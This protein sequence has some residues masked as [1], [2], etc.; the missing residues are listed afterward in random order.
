MKEN[1]IKTEKK[2]VNFKTLKRLVLLG[3]PYKITLFMVAFLAVFLSIVSVASTYLMKVI[4]DDYILKRDFYGMS[5]MVAIKFSLLVIEAAGMISFSYYTRFLAQNVVRD[6]RNQIFSYMIRF[7]ISYYNKSSVGVLVTRV[8]SDLERVSDVFSSGFFEIIADILKIIAILAVMFYTNWKLALVVITTIPIIVYGTFWFQKLMR[9]AFK[10]V[11]DQVTTLNSFVQERISGMKIVQLF[12]QED[13]TYQKFEEINRKH[14]KAWLKNIWLN[15]VFFPFI[16][17]VSSLAIALIVW[18]GGLQ[19]L[20]G[21]MPF[22][23]ILMFIQLTRMLF[24]PLRQIADKYN[25]LQLGMVS[26]TRVFEI[27]DTRAE[28]MEVSGNKQLSNVQGNIRFENVRFSYQPNEEILKGISFEVKKGEMVAFVG[29]TGAGKST[30]INLINRFYDVQEG[31]VFVDN[32]NV[33]D[34][35]LDSLRKH[36]GTV[37]QD[38]FLF[39]DS[40]YNNITLKNPTIS[41]EE[42]QQAAKEIGIHDFIM[43]LPGDYHYNVKER[44]LVLSAGQRQLIAFLRVYVHN[45]EILILDEATSSIDSIS[46]KMLQNASEKMMQGRTSIVIAHRLSTIQKADKIIVL[47]K[48]TII[49]MGTHTQLLTKEN[50]YYANLVKSNSIGKLL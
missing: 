7:K 21:E 28:H 36:I 50:G 22:G 41:L 45:P 31:S 20:N 1:N 35:T 5:L 49:E 23:S 16:E 25:N 26:S 43:Q 19:A 11:R 30:I 2:E 8:M 33:K 18:Y 34:F 29:A 38:V 4:V 39:S 24:N 6:V 42:V 3:K 37:L 27:I 15:S 32:Q 9:E 46:E 12:G 48:G 10:Q 14:E 13:F 44:G 17:V 47:D 40:I